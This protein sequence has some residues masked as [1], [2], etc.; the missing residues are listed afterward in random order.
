MREEQGKVRWRVFKKPAELPPPPPPE[1]FDIVLRTDKGMAP[2]WWGHVEACCSIREEQECS[3]KLHLL[4]FSSVALETDFTYWLWQPQGSLPC[5]QWWKNLWLK[6]EVHC[7]LHN[8]SPFC[9]GDYLQVFTSPF[10]KEWDKLIK[11][12]TFWKS[13]NEYR[14]QGLLQSGARGRGGPG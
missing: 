11:L 9:L 5:L 12:F 8:K 3:S 1:S 7:S 10:G 4:L 6:A 13:S 2:R 14:K